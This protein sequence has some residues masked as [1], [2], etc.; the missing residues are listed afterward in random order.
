MLRS[1]LSSLWQRMLLR[2]NKVRRQH[3][4]ESFHA[5]LQMERDAQHVLDARLKVIELLLKNQGR[6]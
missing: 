6:R 5:R 4:R 2:K 3:E 1:K